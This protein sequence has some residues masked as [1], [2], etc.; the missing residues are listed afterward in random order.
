[1][2]SLVFPNA[3][4]IFTGNIC[5]SSKGGR[6]PHPWYTFATSYYHHHPCASQSLNYYNGQCLITTLLKF[7]S[8]VKILIEIHN[9]LFLSLSVHLI[10][11]LLMRMPLGILLQLTLLLQNMLTITLRFVTTLTW[12]IRSSQNR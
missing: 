2:T 10:M 1:M 12:S 4:S 11:I 3:N 5:N 8:L 6:V 7:T 9:F